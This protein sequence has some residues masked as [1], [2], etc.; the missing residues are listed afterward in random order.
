MYSYNFVIAHFVVFFKLHMKRKMHSIHSFELYVINYT[1][2]CI[3]WTGPLFRKVMKL[4]NCH[5]HVVC[6]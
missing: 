4:S 3:I 6:L 5:L 1:S 2:R